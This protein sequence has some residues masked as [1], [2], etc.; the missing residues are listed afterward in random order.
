[1]HTM[2]HYAISMSKFALS[3]GSF[4]VAL[5]IGALISGWLAIEALGFLT[6]SQM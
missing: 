1:M 2:K 5:I 6:N 4:G 3:I